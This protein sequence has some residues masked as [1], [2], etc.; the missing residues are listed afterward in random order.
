[1]VCNGSTHVVDAEATVQQTCTKQS[2]D[3]F[4]IKLQTKNGFINVRRIMAINEEGALDS[5]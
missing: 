5:P 2:L 1:V 3:H 4:Q